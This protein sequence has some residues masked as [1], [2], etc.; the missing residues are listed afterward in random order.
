MNQVLLGADEALDYWER[1][2]QAQGDLQSGGHV[3]LDTAANEI[4]YAVRLGK[5]LGALGDLP[6]SQAPTLVLDAGCGKGW[7]A[8]ALK[9]C[10]F[11]VHGID[12]SPTAIESC[13]L[14]D[15]H[16]RYAVATLSDHVAP[17]LYDAVVAVDVLFH[18]TDDVVWMRSLQNLSSL[19]NFGG[20][21]VI[22]AD[23]S[24]HRRILGDYIVH[25]PH[26]EYID[27]LRPLGF[28]FLDFEPYNFRDNGLGFSSFTRIG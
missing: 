19:V 2:H 14:E 25:R 22:S 23:M 11:Q 12:A 27:L 21:L 17:H 15:A 6:G 10:G 26:Q 7:F 1:R 3:G 5:L 16:G 28:H 9:R 24:D 18:L 8:R 4:F 13:L 20:R